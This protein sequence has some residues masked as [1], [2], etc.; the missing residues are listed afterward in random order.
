LDQQWNIKVEEN[1]LVFLDCRFAFSFYFSVA[2]S[3]VRFYECFFLFSKISSFWVA[4]E[5]SKLSIM[6]ITVNNFFLHIL[7]CKDFCESKVIDQNKSFF[8]INN[9]LKTICCVIILSWSIFSTRHNTA[10]DILKLFF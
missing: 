8:I 3:L 2:F 7:N 4:L 6:Q 10:K 9:N 5:L 1:S